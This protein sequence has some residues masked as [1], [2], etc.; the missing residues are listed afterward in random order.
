MWRG[1][2]QRWEEMVEREPGGGVG[3]DERNR[4]PDIL[5]EETAFWEWRGG[6]SGERDGELIM[7]G[8]GLGRGDEEG[9]DCVDVVLE[10]KEEG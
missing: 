5:D 8:G 3:T 10:H 4:N 9:M 2:V 1:V 6:G 7:G